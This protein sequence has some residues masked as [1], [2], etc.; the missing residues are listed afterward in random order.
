VA[1]FAAVSA[2]ALAAAAVALAV[3]APLDEEQ[4]ESARAAPQGTLPQLKA[5]VELSPAGMRA[6]PP[7]GLYPA[8]SAQLGLAPP[9]KRA[10]ASARR[11]AS[12]REGDVSYAVL[13]P[14]GR[15]T[16]ADT[17]QTYESASLIKAMILVAYLRRVAAEGRE[18]TELE[19]LRMDDMIRV[20]DNFS[21]TE[22][23]EGL[24]PEALDELAAEAGMRDFA[25]SVFWGNCIVTAA[26]QVRFF[27][28]L[29]RLLPAAQRDFARKLLE[30]VA[31]FHSWGIP[32]AARPDWR[33]FFKGGWRPDGDEGQIVH[34]SALLERGTSKLALAVLTD[35]NPSESYAHATI[36]GIARRIVTGGV[37][38]GVL[39]PLGSLRDYRPPAP[40]PLE[41]TA[42]ARS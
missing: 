23:W 24:G 20:S 36:E 5:P 15:I 14:G 1:R 32:Q 6:A 13:G 35:E 17:D 28:A 29:D 30:N 9:S 26:D 22:L 25:T 39:V 33:V 40:R 2:L 41:P 4:A 19:Q 8:L 38:P 21:A 16:G 37:E 34:Q 18:P 27:L 11:F 3:A 42:Q 7:L 10:L 12:K 31:S